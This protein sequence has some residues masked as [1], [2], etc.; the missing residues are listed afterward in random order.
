MPNFDGQLIA[1]DPHGIHFAEAQTLKWL[2]FYYTCFQKQH[3][4]N[5]PVTVT[6]KQD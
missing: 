4:I 6:E 2:Y 1:D 3:F 5:N